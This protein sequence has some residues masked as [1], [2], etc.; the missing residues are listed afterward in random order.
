[1]EQFIID[2]FGEDKWNII[3]AESGVSYPWISSCAYADKVT[4]E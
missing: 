4:Y 3:L 2:S 1:M